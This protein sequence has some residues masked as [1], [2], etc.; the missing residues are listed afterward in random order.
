MVPCKV[1]LASP[2]LLA[3]GVTEGSEILTWEHNLGVKQ[4]LI[5]GSESHIKTYQKHICMTQLKM[6]YSTLYFK[7]NLIFSV[8]GAQRKTTC[9][10]NGFDLL[11]S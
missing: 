5:N 7:W 1:C 10:P 6:L 2:Q 8:E 9:S 3:T 11:Q 4:P